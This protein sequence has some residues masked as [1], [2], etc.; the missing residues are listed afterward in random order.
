MPET[1]HQRALWWA[2]GGLS[3]IGW[4]IAGAWSWE[5]QKPGSFMAK[6]LYINI[7]NIMPGAGRTPIEGGLPV[8]GRVWRKGSP[9]TL[10]T[11]MKLVRPRCRAV[12]RT[13]KK[14]K[15]ELLREPAMPLLGVYP[16]QMKAGSWSHICTPTLTAALFTVTRTQ[17]PKCLSTGEWIEQIW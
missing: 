17:Q 13:L 1:W 8:P 9:C 7:R 6:Q 16:E 11:G 14:L 2:V 10:L 5:R 4:H 3:G 15:I 12:W